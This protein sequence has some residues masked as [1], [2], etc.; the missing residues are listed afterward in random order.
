MST[1]CLYPLLTGTVSMLLLN[2]YFDMDLGLVCGQS[3]QNP[4]LPVI[5][6][7]LMLPG[8]RHPTPRWRLCQRLWIIQ[9]ERN[10][11]SVAI[12]CEMRRNHFIFAV[13][14]SVLE[15]F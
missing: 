8:S 14:G 2:P 13:F 5:S 6:V 7:G 10:H 1:P 3:P 12:Y 11:R 15:Q 4:V 9:G